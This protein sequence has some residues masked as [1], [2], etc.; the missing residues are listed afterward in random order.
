MKR[1]FLPLLYVIFCTSFSAKGGNAS[2]HTYYV[3]LNGSDDN[4][5]TSVAH[6]FKTIAKIN[7]LLL[8]AGD[9]VLF[10]GQQT[11]A[12]TMILDSLDGG[13]PGK[14]VTIGSFGKG[15]AVINAGNATALTCNN[16]SYIT[17]TGLHL[18]GSGAE[19]NTGS[20]VYFNSTRTDES[21]RGIVI[22]NCISEGFRD[23]GILINC[24]EGED[25]KGFDSVTISNCKVT[26]NGEAGI[27]SL[28]GQTS[29]HHTNIHITHCTAFLNK[30][31]HNKTEGHSGNGIVMSSVQHLVIED[32]LAYEN[33]AL[34]NCSAG[35]P[36]GIWMWICKDAVVQRCES[37]HNHAGLNK[38]GGGFDIDGGCANCTLQYN[39]SHDNEGAGYLLAEYGAG[40]PFTNNTVRFNISQNDG[41]KNG[42][43]GIAFWGVNNEFK[44]TN[45]MVYNNTVFVSDAN[46]VNGMPAAVMTMGNSLSHVLVANNVFIT[47]GAARF[48]N[49]DTPLDTAVVY[50]AGNNYVSQS[51]GYQFYYN[52]AMVNSLAAWLAL[53]PPQE[54][55]NGR[56]VALSQPPFYS[57]AGKVVS[58]QGQL[59]L[60]RQ[61]AAYRLRAGKTPATGINLLTAFGTDTGPA[62]F[63]G[64]RPGPRFMNGT[65]AVLR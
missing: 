52:N 11:F 31:L 14:P 47:N 3:S 53:C 32:C 5:G 54:T 56:A 12:G 48:I 7:S 38:D 34:N 57:A 24:A 17:I 65:G 28:G 63:F 8:H 26:A 64:T 62:D 10:Q 33:G 2:V 18:K 59:N 35:G 27:G 61:V 46:L 40:M 19:Q 30:G 25:I 37:H 45:T 4:A 16:C 44:V 21:C 60:P 41:R 58:A 13:T 42:Y 49:S 6:A 39:Y 55:Y 23:F 43:G 9:S 20:G 1:L 22:D 50:F 15:Y 29:F 51:N 36:V